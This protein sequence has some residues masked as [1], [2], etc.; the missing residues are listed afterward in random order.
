MVMKMRSTYWGAIFLMLMLVAVSGAQAQDDSQYVGTVAAPEFPTGV[1]WL[2]VPAPL[3]LEGLRGKIVLLDFWTYGCIN[4][5]HM[6]PILEQ[7]EQKYP[8]ELVV[9][10]VH[11][12]KFENEGKTENIRQIIQR[13]ELR[14]PVINDFEFAVWQ[15]YAPFGVN[16]WPT[17][18][19]IDPRGNIVA[20]QSGEVPFESFDNVIAGMVNFYTESGELNRE[21]LELALEGA[22]LPNNPL[23]FPGKVLAD[24][25][26][27]RLFIADTNH[28]RIIIADLTTYEVLDVIGSGGRGFVDGSYSEAA[29]NKPHGMTLDGDTLY[30][31]DTENH[32]IRAVDLAGRG[33]STVAGT[34][35]QTY[36]RNEIGKPTEVALSSPWD[37]EMVGDVLYIAMAGPHQL[38]GLSFADDVIGPV[39]GSSIEGLLDANFAGAQLAQPSGLYHSD[40]LLYF[41]DSESSSIRVADLNNRETYTVAGPPQGL[42]EGALFEFGDIDGVVGESRLQHPLDVVGADNGLIYVADTYNNKIKVIDPATNIITTLTGQGET[43]G[44]LD[45]DFSAALFDEPGGL[46]YA[47]G[48]LY[49]A[50][51]NNHA[52]RVVDLEA[53][54]VSSVAFPNPEALQFEGQTTVIGGNVAMGVVIELAEQTVAAGEGEILLNITL[55]EGYKIN[56]LAPSQAEWRSEGEALMIDEAQQSLPIESVEVRVPVTL[57]A[58]SATLYGDLSIYYCEAEEQTLCFIDQVTVEAP[59]VVAEG[60]GSAVV[61]EREI[62]EP[63]T[64]QN[65]GL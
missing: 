44:F 50:D 15:T 58:G 6:V 64:L 12:A 7:L 4:C 51:T 2:N 46:D 56:D 57:S 65:S 35:V 3:S 23:A 38:W 32:A 45:G 40:G 21:P 13:Y 14:H 8:N 42:I 17:F 9:I 18:I 52:I 55:P 31:A 19:L 34:G 29:F 26:G 37:V 1:D 25:Q 61:V 22:E 10:G 54:T 16:A 53:G 28:H 60:G 63:E 39:V 47:N 20:R 48:K 24:A 49:V 59:V 43:G 5:I 27:N 11:S 41:A 62:P 30:V 36:A 33:V